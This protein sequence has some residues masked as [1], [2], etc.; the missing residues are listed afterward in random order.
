MRDTIFGNQKTVD[1]E[2]LDGG[3]LLICA[4]TNFDARCG[5]C[6]PVLVSKFRESIKESGSNLKVWACSHIGGHKYAGNVIAYTRRPDGSVAGD[7]YSQPECTSLF[8]FGITFL[9]C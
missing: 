2:S 7:W 4:H 5:A 3:H 1:E 8:C 9:T 6:G